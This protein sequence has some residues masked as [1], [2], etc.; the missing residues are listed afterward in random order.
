V[1]GLRGETENLT[2]MSRRVRAVR[3]LD[4][5]EAPLLPNSEI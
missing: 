4:R 2:L 3:A 5:S 1:R